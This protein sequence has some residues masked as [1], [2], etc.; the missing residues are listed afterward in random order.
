MSA[1]PSGPPSAPRSARTWLGSP[2]ELHGPYASEAEAE[3][4]LSVA[5]AHR[6]EGQ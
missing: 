6:V 4:A 2:F 3:K 1:P 5:R